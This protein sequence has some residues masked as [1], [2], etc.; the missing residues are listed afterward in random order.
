MWRILA[1]KRGTCGVFNVKRGFHESKLKSDWVLNNDIIRNAIAPKRLDKENPLENKRTNQNRGLPRNSPNN[2]KPTNFHKNK[3]ERPQTRKNISVT[4]STGSERDKQAAN[5]VLS[6]I[7]RMNK[8]GLINTINVDDNKVHQTNIRIFAKGIDLSKVGFSIVN[9]EQLNETT[10]IPLVKIVDRKV[11]LKKYSDEIANRKQKEL[12]SMGILKRRPSKTSEADKGE[13]STKRI[14]VSWQIKEDDL[15][16]QKTHEII[17]QLK[18]GYK[19]HLCI[20]DRNNINAK[21]WSAGFENLGASDKVANKVLSSS[22]MKKRTFILDKLSG[23]A[24]DYSVQP[25]H[26]GTIETKMLI[27]LAPK[28][29]NNKDREALKEQRRK[30]RQEKLMKRLEKQKQRE[31]EYQQ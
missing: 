17:S 4:W 18:K 20:D 8:A 30:E 16:K 10:Q 21:N 19:V 5:S 15:S 27:K 12:Q 28:T 7:F 11:A 2:F 26:E 29:S 6:Q 24:D 13:D 23:I 14:K 9:F 1:L 25:V 3:F 31:E 22:E